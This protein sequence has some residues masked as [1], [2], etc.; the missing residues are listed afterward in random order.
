MVTAGPRAPQIFTLRPPFFV[1]RRR[2]SPGAPRR[3]R[4]SF[5]H[6]SGKTVG[7][8]AGA[9]SPRPSFREGNFAQMPGR[10]RVGPE[11]RSANAPG[12]AE[13]R[14]A[15]CFARARLAVFSD[16]GIARSAPALS[17]GLPRRSQA[18]GCVSAFKGARR[19][20]QSR[21]GDAEIATLAPLPTNQRRESRKRWAQQTRFNNAAYRVGPP[22]GRRG[23]TCCPGLR[24]TCAAA[25]PN[26]SS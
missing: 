25:S 16:R 10:Q 18:G 11:R 5:A 19:R 13:A 12:G 21:L 9:K 6:S 1:G 4:K 23:R 3:G 8:L 14:A 15:R 24:W 17:C 2:A 20:R 22:I 7:I 26:Q